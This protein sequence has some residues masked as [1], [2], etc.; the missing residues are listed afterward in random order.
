[1]GG[2]EEAELFEGG[3]EEEMG[4]VND[5]QRMALF[6][7]DQVVESGADAGHHFGL[8]KGRLVAE[9]HQDIA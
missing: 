5:H 3:W 7:V 6:G 2:E 4:F 1:M 9:G 8:A